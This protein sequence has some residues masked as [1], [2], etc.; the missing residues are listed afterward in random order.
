MDGQEIRAREGDNLLQTCLENDIY[1]PNLCYL[2]GMKEPPAS[3][4]LCF[5]E[6][7]GEKSPVTSCT[8]QVS[9]GMV[10]QTDTP[11]VRRLQRAALQLLL[12]AHHVDCGPC[13]ANKK[14]DL[15]RMAKFL[16]V[17]LKPKALENLI[18]DSRPDEDHLCLLY[19]PDR[20]VLCGKCVYVCRTRHG[21]PHLTFAKRGLATTVSFYGEKDTAQTPCE[22]C[23]S[24]VEVCPVAAI[25]L[26]KGIKKRY[27][28]H[29]I[30]QK[31]K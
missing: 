5:V 26:K 12:S 30:R 14:C 23:L 18:K 13:P 4:R 9:T 3:C 8:I 24:C 20:C 31:D 27:R 6:V 25:M 1:I 21:R 29:G 10:V 11:S 2:E 19:F 17:G 28:A 7:E 22:T 15:Q 16:K